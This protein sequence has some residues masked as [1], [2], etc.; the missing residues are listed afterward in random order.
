V[1]YFVK[2]KKEERRTAMKMKKFII[3]AILVFALT[4]YAYGMGSHHHHGDTN[5]GGSITTD[6][7]GGN[8]A[9]FQALNTNG[10]SVPVSV[11]EPTTILLLASGLIGLGAYAGRKFKK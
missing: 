6:N 9:T 11:P 8:E 1:Q 5:S 10:G 4:N 2:I 3:P 7:S